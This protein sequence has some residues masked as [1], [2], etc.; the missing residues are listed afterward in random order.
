MF[1]AVTAY[2]R[3]EGRTTITL[4]IVQVILRGC[5]DL[6]HIIGQRLSVRMNQHLHHSA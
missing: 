5:G 2:M 1:G 6:V 4:L 3:Q